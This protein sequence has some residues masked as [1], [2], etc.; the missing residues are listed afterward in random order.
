[1]NEDYLKMSDQELK[2][3]INILIANGKDSSG[4]EAELYNRLNCR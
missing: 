1:M 3:Y 2:A 4:A